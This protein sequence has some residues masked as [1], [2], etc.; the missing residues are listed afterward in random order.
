[1]AA[2]PIKL[3][4]VVCSAEQLPLAGAG[5]EAAALEAADAAV[6]LDDARDR[7]DH[8]AALFAEPPT[9]LGL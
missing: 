8:S 7:L 1:M 9:V 2:L 6:V 3:A 4:Q 5:L